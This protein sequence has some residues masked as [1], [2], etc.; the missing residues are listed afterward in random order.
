MTPRLA[1]LLVIVLLFAS[2]LPVPFDLSVSQSVAVASKMTR[3]N[4]GTI[5]SS[6]YDPGSSQSGFAFSP[7]VLA[8]GGFDYSAGFVTALDNLAVSVQ[9]VS[10]GG[11]YGQQ[12]QS[13]PNPDAHAPPYIAWPAKSGVSWLFGAVFDALDPTKNGYAIFQGIP[14]A[15]LSSVSGNSFTAV[16]GSFTSRALGAS[17]TANPSTVFDDLHILDFDTGPSAYT[18]WNFKVQSPSLAG[19][20]NSFR[21]GGLFYSLPFIPAGI[22]RVMYFYDENMAADPLRFPNR[23]FGSWYDSSKGGWVTYA[24]WEQPV[25][26]FFNKQLPI[27]HRID[28]LLTTGQLLSTEGGT[29]RLY[30]RDGSLL[31]SF[32]LGNLVYIGEQYVGGVARAYFSQCLIFSHQLHFNVYWIPSDQMDKLG[33]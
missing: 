21:N 27:D 18:E 23:S 1:A 11:Q 14:G 24:W 12:S 17:V 30:D 31:A 5:S 9:G 20:T 13:I 32:P 3:D 15:S 4:P 19:G 33:M 8:T 7:S 25:G 6:N 22:S 16:M 28:A 29:G 2:C 26:T 10:G